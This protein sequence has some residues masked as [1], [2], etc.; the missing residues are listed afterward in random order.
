MRRPRAWFAATSPGGPGQLVRSYYVGLPLM[1]VRGAD[2]GRRKPP[3]SGWVSALL[4]RPEAQPRGQKS[5]RWSAEWRTCRSP[6]T[7]TPQG[8]GLLVAP[9]GV[10]S[11]RHVRR[12]RKRD[13]VPGAGQ[14]TRAADLCP[15]GC[16]T[17]E[18]AGT[19]A[20]GYLRLIL[21]SPPK[22]K[23]RRASSQAGHGRLAHLIIRSRVNRDRW[24]GGHRCSASASFFET[25]T[26]RCAPQHEETGRS[27]GCSTRE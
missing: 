5:R 25:R 8:V 2:E 10:P 4:P 13:G 3:G 14:T 20:L 21:R 26:S 17:S 1:A 9:L 6:G 19:D 7:S 15:P 22:R 16:L 11:P 12:G 18:S 23:R 24:T 27:V